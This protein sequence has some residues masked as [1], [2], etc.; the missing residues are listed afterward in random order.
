MAYARS[1]EG[2]GNIYFNEDNF[3]KAFECFEKCLPMLEKLESEDYKA[4]I[5]KMN[6]CDEHI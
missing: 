2:L 5:N 6:K 3:S 1:F 4:V